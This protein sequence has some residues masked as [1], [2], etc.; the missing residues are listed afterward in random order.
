[1]IDKLKVEKCFRKSIK[2]YNTNATV[3]EK[4]CNNVVDLISNYKPTYNNVLE[5]GC[6]TGFLTKAFLQKYHP[7]RYTAND[8]VEENKKSIENIFNTLPEIDFSFKSGDAETMPF[9]KNVDLIISSSTVQWF[10]NLDSFMNKAYDLLLPGGFFVFS[11]F[12]T[13][14]LHEI[15]STCNSGL[16]YLSEKEILNIVSEKFS[17]LQINEE[18]HY[19]RFPQPLSV[20]KHMKLT[21]VNGNNSKRWSAKDFTAFDKK[22]RRLCKNQDD[23]TLTYHPVYVVA[24]KQ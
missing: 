14:N 3:Q 23:V 13:D 20:L 16:N 4:I 5:I 11:T 9:E 10:N 21:G 7:S 2:T 15:R 1:M 22:Y 6:G 17:V 12:G 8:L 19:L 24:V 18:H